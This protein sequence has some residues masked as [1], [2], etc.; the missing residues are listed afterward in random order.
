MEII[1]YKDFEGSVET[2]IERYCCRGKILFI[3]DLITYESETLQGLQ[4]QF[5]ESVE[6]YIET[7]KQIGKEPQKPFKGLFNVRIKPELHRAAVKKA[8][9]EETSL[10]DLVSKALESYL[11]IEAM[12]IKSPSI[13]SL[14]IND[15]TSN[16]GSE[17][18][19]LRVQGDSAAFLEAN[20][21][22]NNKFFTISERLNVVH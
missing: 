9:A 4:K 17:V 20:S 11:S 13:D 18:S 8:A 12:A 22:A 10:N 19:I 14:Q 3:D 5:E 21:S 2:D 16:A 1:K 7:C 6:D 15:M